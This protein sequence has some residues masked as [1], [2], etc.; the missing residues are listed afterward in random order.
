MYVPHFFGPHLLGHCSE[1]YE[2]NRCISG[3]SLEL[4][5]GR[6]L[7]WN[8]SDGGLK[9]LYFFFSPIVSPDLDN[10]YDV[11]TNFFQVKYL[12]RGA[13]MTMCLYYVLLYFGIGWFCMKLG[14]TGSWH[15]MLHCISDMEVEAVWLLPCLT[16]TTDSNGHRYAASFYS[17]PK[18]RILLIGFQ[19]QNQWLYFVFIT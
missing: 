5:L 15:H 14:Y 8:W 11:C 1:A 3:F 17:A 4:F 19:D 2:R 7:W 13:F 16:E 12:N 6:D 10:T 9:W 18:M